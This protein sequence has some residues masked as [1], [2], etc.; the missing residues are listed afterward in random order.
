MRSWP[1]LASLLVNSGDEFDD[2]S[3]IWRRSR[4]IGRPPRT[5][6]CRD[7]IRTTPGG[8]LPYG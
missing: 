1:V 3:V 4:T 8:S 2:G 6:G 5:A 7:S